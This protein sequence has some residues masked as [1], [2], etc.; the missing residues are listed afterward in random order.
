[1]RNELYVVGVGPG[2]PG[3]LTAE[4]AKII[5]E[6]GCVASAPRNAV[7][8]EGH[9]NILPLGDFAAA[10]ERIRLELEKGSVAVLVSGDPGMYSLLPLIKKKF[11]AARLR[12]V[13]G[14]SA[15]QYLCCE[16]GES[17]ENAVILSGH[18][19]PLSAACL[20]TAADRNEKTIFFCGGDKSPQW[21]CETLAANEMENIEVTVGERLSYPDQR[22]SCGTPR[23]LSGRGFDPLSVVLI[24][25]RAP[26][27]PPLGR[28]RDEDFIRSIV[29]MTKSEVRS[30]ILDKLELTRGAVL[31]DIGAG[32][33]SVAVSAALICPDCE[34]YA[35]DSDARAAALA[36]EN[37]KKFH[38]F[39]M[40]VLHGRGSE[41]ISRL[42]APTHIFI[43][44]SGGELRGLLTRAAGFGGRVRVVVSAV[45]LRTL[46]EACE[47]MEGEGFSEFEAV[48]L[49]VSRSK[50]LGNSRIMAA[51]NPV[52][53]CSA[54]TKHREDEVTG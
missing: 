11:P 5:E 37:R 17:H 19:R 41:I 10:F 16:A 49:S 28:P 25:N 15:M 18:G 35:V 7:L 51:Q 20:L 50:A 8:A 44:G 22:I 48:Q 27:T 36:E 26:W 9:G 32:T 14:I 38:C 23:Q 52:T 34:I 21:V 53:V 29:P 46:R 13:P 30:V 42:P 43:G 40:S 2:S 54:W 33:G 31:W 12:V 1:M 24:R 3:F 45:S 47:V 4:A 6:A 39:N